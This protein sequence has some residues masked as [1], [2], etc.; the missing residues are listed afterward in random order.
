MVHRTFTVESPILET[1]KP[2]RIILM[3]NKCK[4]RYE[5]GNGQIK[6]IVNVHMSTAINYI[7]SSNQ[8]RLRNLDCCLELEYVKHEE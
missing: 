4:A 6:R 7:T 8:K 5:S 3:A 1:K 2:L